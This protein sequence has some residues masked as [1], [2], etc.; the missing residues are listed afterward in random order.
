MLKTIHSSI[1]FILIFISIALSF[2]LD[3]YKVSPPISLHN[4][5]DS[6]ITGLAITNPKGHCIKLSNCKNIK[7]ID[8]KL[9]PSSGNGVDLY[10]SEN[11]LITN[12]WMERIQTGVYAHKCKSVVVEYNEVK[13]VQ[14]P[15]PRG[16]MTQFN[17]V[18]GGENR[19]NYNRCENFLGESYP[20]DII[21]I[22]K[23]N[24]TE[25]KPIQIIGNWIRGGGPSN[26]GG[27]IMTGDNG[28]SFI[29]VEDNI[30]V[31]PGQYGIAISSGTNIQILNNMVYGKKQPFTNVGLYVWNQYE[32]ECADHI[33]EGNIINFT[34]KEGN[35]NPCW[36]SGNCSNTIFSNQCGANIDSTILPD[37]ILTKVKDKNTSSVAGYVLLQNYPNPFNPVTTISYQLPRHTDVDLRIYNMMGVE[38]ASLVNEI[39]VAGSY[40]V[41]WDASIYPSGMYYYRILA[42]GFS[43]TKKCLLLK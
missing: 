33:V 28:G 8:C 36:N 7:I 10:S 34:N 41:Q 19:I 39:Q 21:N 43:E 31:D 42:A 30:L 12:N 37:E 38:L 23:S 40:Q 20:E 11:I 1:L 25:E 3:Q 5:S 29:L 16:Q 17:A 4:V 9:G 14:G 32:T 18:Y 24:G 22:Y 27:G 35:K 2:D 13:N 26:S 15:F 6:T